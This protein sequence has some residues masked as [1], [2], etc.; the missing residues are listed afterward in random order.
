MDAAVSEKTNRRKL[1]YTAEFLDWAG[2]QG[3]HEEDVLPPS[4]ATLCNYA[5]LF[6]GKLAGGT[7]RA[8]LSAVKS[9]V[10][11]R[12]LVWNG[13][14]SL[15]NVLSGVE[16]RAP[17]S[18]F[19]EQRPPVKKEHLS[20]LFDELDLS[21]ACGL[22]RALAAASAG[23]FYSQLRGG[24]I[25]PPSADPNDYDSSSFPTV[26]DLR[27]PNKNGDRKLK[28]PK[29]KVSQS[30]GEEVIYSPQ[31]GR[32]SP[33]RAWREH[34][35]VNRLGP[36]D[37]L[38]AYREDNGELKVLTKPTFLKRCNAVWSKHNIPRMTG[39]CFRIGGTTHY[40]VIG[41]PPD[42]VKALGR[43]K[44]DAFLRYWRDLESLASIHLHLTFRLP[45]A[46][47]AR[48]LHTSSRPILPSFYHSVFHFTAK[49]DWPAQL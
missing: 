33:T 17:S 9:W 48:T 46:H 32:T 6:A 16:R 21:D 43:W 30:R 45:N 49:S 39:H 42:V 19:R 25:F 31:P 37:P 18:S 13:R 1:L 41:I 29:T 23:C 47:T 2:E 38:M 40:L 36:D 4:E 15:R 22:D 28:L 14:D 34:I 8:K 24:E 35:R 3:L 11:R 44:S 7:T 20:I 26:K 27:P 10:Q 5:A 12:G